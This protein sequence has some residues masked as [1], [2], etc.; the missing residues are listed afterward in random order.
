MPDPVPSPRDGA[1][2]R[3]PTAHLRPPAN[4]IND[5]NGLVHHDGW[6]HVFFQHNP[7][8]PLHRDMHWGHYRSRDLVS[9]EPLPVALT[10]SPGGDDA[11]GC[12]SGNAVSHDGRITAFYSAHRTDRWWQPVAVADSDPSGTVFTKRRGLAVPSAPEDVTTF[13]D[14]Y[15]W[16]ASDGWRML[17]GAGMRDGSGA[18]L[19]Y[20]SADLRTW[21]YRGPLHARADS[22]PGLR[23]GEAWECPQLAVFEGGRVLLLTSAWYQRTGPG[24]VAGWAGRA[25]ADGHRFGVPFRLDHGPDF[26]APAL[27]PAPDGRWLLW[28]WAWEAR[29]ERRTL[30]AGW[31]GVLTVP[32]EV[33]LGADGRARQAPAREVDGLRTGSPLTVQRYALPGE[34]VPFGTVGASCDLRLKVAFRGQ[35]AWTLRIAADPGGGTGGTD[36]AAGAAGEYL[37]LRIA[38]GFVTVDRGHASADP[39]SHV[40]SY[41]MPLPQAA[42]GRTVELRLL[43]DRSVAELF[44]DAGEALTLRYYPEHRG[45]WTLVSRGDAA[46]EVRLDV[47]AHDVRPAVLAGRPARVPG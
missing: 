7:H 9:W 13:R 46:D 1:D 14:P 32:R 39:D 24:H 45:P 31:A 2:H 20:E 36:G 15:V 29:A 30:E 33:T 37:E 27:L 16:R 47:I 10:P 12:F 21:T 42:P 28:G 18:A 44:S 26:Y 41:R 35:A 22:G 17:V 11:D 34:S 8:S 5:P 25:T 19:L 40:G 23:T 6:Y 43:L 3:L 4:W 38:D